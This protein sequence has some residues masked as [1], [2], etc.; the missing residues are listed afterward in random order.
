MG[1][2]N[3]AVD[4][5]NALEFRTTGICNRHLSM[6]VDP[7]E[8]SASIVI[9]KEK[10]AVEE[11]TSAPRTHSPSTK[12][13]DEYDVNVVVLII[14]VIAGLGLIRFGYIVLQTEPVSHWFGGLIN[15]VVQLTGLGSLILGV[16]LV[17]SPIL[18]EMKPNKNGKIKEEMKQITEFISDINERPK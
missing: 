13:T 16:F 12:S 4:G 6:G 15:L 1:E 7:L 14:S 5:C 3:C 18:K 17:L 9:M 2:R 11:K 8:D 10:E